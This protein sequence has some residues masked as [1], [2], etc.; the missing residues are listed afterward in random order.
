MGKTKAELSTT[1]ANILGDAI[2]PGLFNLVGCVG[3]F[4][5]FQYFCFTNFCRR[6]RS[7]M[8]DFVV[9]Y[10]R[11]ELLKV[12]GDTPSPWCHNEPPLA[13]SYIQK[14]HWD[15]GFLAYWDTKQLP[16]F[17]LAVPC[18]LM[19][20]HHSWEFVQVHWDYVKRLGLVDNNL[21]GMPR[22][23][24]LAVRQ[25]RV[26]PR[27]CFVYVVHATA[28]T[29]FGIFFMHVQV[30]TRLL[31]ASSPVLPWLA[32]IL[33]TRRDKPAVALAEGE[34][35]QAEALLKIEC[36]TNLESSTDTI[37]FQEKLDTDVSRW[38]MMYFLGYTLV[39]TILF[40]NH[41]PWT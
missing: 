40:C 18:V 3:S 39:G 13:Y 33:T 28:L 25:C 12:A 4:I 10:G 8:D 7:E 37:L 29:I 30:T 9:D 2:I 6:E 38:V 27:E 22:R 19:V 23:P 15:N 35:A 32:A 41:L 20:L 34:E 36:K 24:C 5:F 11:R 17:L 16:N 1:I 14:V 26:L 21:L 31:L